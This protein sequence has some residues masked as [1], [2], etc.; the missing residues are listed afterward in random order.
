LFLAGGLFL[1]QNKGKSMKFDLMTGGMTWQQSAQLAQQLEQQGFSGMLFTEA[2]KVPWMMIASAAMATQQL[3]FSTGIA[4]AFPRSPMMSAQIAWELAEN[5]GGRFRLGLGS[6]V[7]AHVTRRYASTFDKPAPQMRDYVAAVQAC[8]RAFRGEEKLNHE[9]PYHNLNLLPA[10]WSPGRHANEQVKVD[11]SAVGPYM[12]RVAGELCDGLHVHPMHSQH[13]L[14]QRLLP[15]VE[16]GTKKAGRH[17]NDIDL[18]IPVF[19]IAGDSEEERAAM[20]QRARTQI[21]FYGSTP[22]YA[23]QFDDL[24]F[25]GT[26]QKLGALMKQGD[27]EGLAATINDEILNHFAVVARWDDMADALTQRYGDIASRVVTYLA[28]EDIYRNPDHLPRWGEIARAV[29]G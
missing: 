21:A 22:N 17:L 8:L 13:Y 1:A 9:G 24:G 16:T 5:T 25:E 18:I 4:V 6:Q 14:K 12:C 15:E 23:Y 3:E 11:I 27:M 7:K 29:S 19:A 28:A 20:T 10:Q 26:T 2:A